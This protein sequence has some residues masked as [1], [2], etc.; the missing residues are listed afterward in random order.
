[1]HNHSHQHNHGHTA[2][3]HTLYR[4]GNAKGLYLALLATTVIMIVEFL[5]GLVT[6]SLAL[7]SDS[8]HML[9]DV[10]ALAFSLVAMWFARKPPSSKKTYSFYRFEILAA[11]F[12]AITLFIIAGV[13]IWEAYQRLF[14]PPSVSSGTMMVIAAIGLA[15]NLFSAWMLIRKGDISGNM[16]V[17][18]A[19]LH[20][21]SD[22][23][24]SIGAII[25]GVLMSAFSWYIADPI[26]SV[27]VAV[28]IIK[29]AWRVIDESIHILMEGTPPTINI[30][31]VKQKLLAIP[32]VGNIHDLHIWTVTSGIDSLTCHLL[33]DN[34]QLNQD[35]LRQA[36]LVIEEQFGI[37]HTTIQ[38]ET[39]DLQ[40]AE[41]II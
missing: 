2:H 40:H 6:N 3:S 18:S 11:L 33:I 37:K 12:N 30:D 22:A 13:I 38:I 1:M 41:Y 19:Y 23:L 15:A 14:A 8:G 35:I 16:N 29:S 34:A 7:L 28:L 26:I 32:G 27:I 9:S 36:I 24:G 25:A 4:D 31:N 5:G 20:V 21:L 10:S 17:R 39:S